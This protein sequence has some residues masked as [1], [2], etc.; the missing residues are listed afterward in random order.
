M[1]SSKEAQIEAAVTNYR[2]G[3]FP[4]IR[5]TAVAHGIPYPTLRRRLQDITTSRRK[6][7]QTQQL[8]TQKQEEKL[9]EWIQ[10]L[11]RVGNAPNHAQVKEMAGLITAASGGP[12]SVGI[13]WV[14]RF[15]QRNPSLR[16]KMGV[17]IEAP[18]YT[19]ASYP[20]IKAWFDRVLRIQTEFGI[21]SLNI[22]NFNEVSLALGVC[23]N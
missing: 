20:T 7:R 18:R 19:S 1:S 17:K 16:T 14:Y 2:T 8:L 5:A 15:L 4:S 9:A 23:T 6:A 21:S 13:N 10:A 11:E 22:W 12:H 3:Q